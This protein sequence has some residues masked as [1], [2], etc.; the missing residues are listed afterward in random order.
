MTFLCFQKRQTSAQTARTKVNKFYQDKRSHYHQAGLCHCL[1]LRISRHV[2]KNDR[3]LHL[4]A[5]PPMQHIQVFP[6][7]ASVVP[8][9]FLYELPCL[10][11]EG[12]PGKLPSQSWRGR[13]KAPVKNRPSTLPTY[14]APPPDI[15]FLGTL[16]E[17]S[18]SRR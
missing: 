12:G 4:P 8:G 16:Q 9:D 10:L 5:V 15:R 3:E 6:Y 1:S 13:R 11:W 17:V 7:D 18:E 2:S 14:P